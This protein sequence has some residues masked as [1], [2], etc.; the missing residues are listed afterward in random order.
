ML[1]VDVDFWW[2]EIFADKVNPQKS[3]PSKITRY[4]VAAL[5]WQAV[6][7]SVWLSPCS[8]NERRPIRLHRRRYN[9]VELSHTHSLPPSPPTHSTTPHTHSLYYPHT[10]SLH[11]PLHPPPHSHPHP[12]TPPPLTLPSPPPLTPGMRWTCGHC[13]FLNHPLMNVCESCEMTRTKS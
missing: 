11:H 7:M 13:T 12:L 4:M 8:S 5:P 10:H 1:L 2:G 3:H 6:G 9:N